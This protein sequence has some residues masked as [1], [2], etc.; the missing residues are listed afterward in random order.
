MKIFYSRRLPRAGPGRRC[1][2]VRCGAARRE[3]ERGV[4]SSL[5]ALIPRN[6]PRDHFRIRLYTCR[7]VAEWVQVASFFLS[8]S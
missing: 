7:V 8:D 1:G 2:A 4:R 6:P 5:D 3:R